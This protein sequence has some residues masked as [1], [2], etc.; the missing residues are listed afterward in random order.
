[1]YDYH[2]QQVTR[3]LPRKGLRDKKT[4]FFRSIASIARAC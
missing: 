1:M 3:L 2:S 4:M